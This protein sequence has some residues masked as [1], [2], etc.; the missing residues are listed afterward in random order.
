MKKE[1]MSEITEFLD[2]CIIEEAATYKKIPKYSGIRKFTGAAAACILFMVVIFTIS[3]NHKI[4]PLGEPKMSQINETEK[5][6]VLEAVTDPPAVE[7]VADIPPVNLSGTIINRN[8]KNIATE[9]GAIVWPWEY[10]TESEQ[11]TEISVNDEQYGSY[12]RT[13]GDALV[14][15]Y[16]GIGEAFGSDIYTDT[17]HTAEYEV[18]EIKNVSQKYRVAVK[19]TDGYYVY[20]NS[21][22]PTPSTFGDMID[23]YGFAHT[24]KLNRFTEMSE[25]TDK[26][27]Y[28]LQDDA[29]IMSYILNCRDAV[30]AGEDWQPNTAP[31]LSF[32]VTSEA[33]GIYKH[34]LYVT[35]DGYIW[36]NIGDYGYS[37]DIGKD[38]AS[39]IIEYAKANANPVEAEPYMYCIIGTVTEIGNGYVMIDDTAAC[40]DENDGRIFKVLTDDIRIRRC[41]EFEPNGI[42]VGST[43][44]VK[45]T[46]P[47]EVFDNDTVKGAVSAY[48]GIIIDNGDILVPA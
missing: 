23:A 32:T 1:K 42:D 6:G 31:Y 10:K 33:L 22:A 4:P 7:T 11:F 15:D 9:N 25:Y 14:G 16:I 21:N 24:V 46:S 43:V 20:G 19:L 44:I 35:C 39:E 26:D 8:Y 29:D 17:L 34:V 41:F 37:F 47:I 28:A 2:D 45:F 13:V 36:T 40:T 38:A 3:E 30:Y 27:T 12:G 18:Y 5:I 48:E